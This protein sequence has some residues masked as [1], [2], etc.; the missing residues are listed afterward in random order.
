MFNFKGTN[1]FYILLLA[2]AFTAVSCDDEQLQEDIIPNI[3]DTS[4]TEV[5]TQLNT[6][7]A[8]ALPTTN[9]SSAD[10]VCF[11]F[12]YPLAFV[13]EDGTTVIA[14]DEDGVNDVFQNAEDTD[15]PVADFAYP[16]TLTLADGSE[17]TVADFEAFITV[18]TDCFGDFEEWGDGDWDGGDH[19]DCPDDFDF[20]GE[21]FTL[22]FPL[23][24]SVNGENVAIESEDAFTDLLSSFDGDT[25]SQF[26]FVFPFSVF[27]LADSSV[28]V[29]ASEEDLGAVLESCDFGGFGGG[30]FDD[31]F[32]DGF[33]F[34]DSLQCFTFAYPL[35]ITFGDEPL[36]LNDEAAFIAALENSTAEGFDFV[37]PLTVNL[38]STGEDQVLTSEEDWAAVFLSCGFGGGGDGG[39]DG[40]FDGGDGWNPNEGYGCFEVNFPLN[41]TINGELVTINSED[42]FVSILTDL[43][44]GGEFNIELAYPVSVTIF[45]DSTTVTI[46]NEEEWEA[47]CDACHFDGGDGDFDEECFRINFPLNV[48]VAGETVAVENE[49]ALGALFSEINP[50]DFGGF[51]FPLSVT[52]LETGEV[53]TV[54]NEEE[55]AG[56]DEF[57]E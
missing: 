43:G 26:E 16:L 56:L 52:I 9:N 57:C 5:Q 10:S 33:I 34:S 7:M 6:A 13:L 47:L 37:Y 38:A 18:L 51:T 21:C 8:R 35:Q 23:T 25:I 29:I 44:D 45:S 46:N 15:N 31:G 39:F 54:N 3:P 4:I 49:E 42:D 20:T 27:V 32:D 2:L 28:V 48:L 50:A 36:T 22:V 24:V 40:D 53:V 1:F 55:L 17:T 11:N 14:D 12:N 41:L 30:D 19:G